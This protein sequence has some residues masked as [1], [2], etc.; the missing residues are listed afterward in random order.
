VVVTGARQ[1]GKTTLARRLYEN[2]FRYLNLDSPGER[3]RLALAPAEGWH[4]AVG[5]AILDEVQKAPMLLDKLKWAY[6]EG[7]LDFSVLLGSSRITLLEQ[8]RESLAGRVFLYELWPLTVGELAP[9]FG[10]R[11][12]DNPFIARLLN[13]LES[14]AALLAPLTRGVVGQ[15]AGAAQ[16]ALVHLLQ[17]GGLPSLLQYRDEEKLA[18]LDAYQT[19][20][21]ERDLADLARLRD[22]EPFS[23]CHRLASLRTGRILSYSEIARDAGLP[24]TTVRRYL[25]YLELSY[26]T[27][28]LNPWAKNPSVRF[29]KSP[30]LIWCDLGVQRVLSG[31]T[32]VLTGEQ[33]ES[34]IISQLMIH[35]WTLGIRVTP[36]F[37]RTSGGSEVDLLLEGEHGILAV[38]IKNRPKVTAKDAASIERSRKLIGDAYQG[39][40]VVY[41]GNEIGQITR[42]VYAIPDWVLLGT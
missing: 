33:Y 7:K 30:K 28:R 24:V 31:Q 32:G 25:G 29:I 6:D 35:L 15:E 11:K 16:S 42:S 13:G 26:Q 34:A 21:L 41:R 17:W 12:P 37:L 38:E 8:V 20:Y 18:W 10:G 36:S 39:G 4:Q 40:L 9:H 1:V 19:T 2:A 22:L 3:A 23:T 14:P 5:P 27:F